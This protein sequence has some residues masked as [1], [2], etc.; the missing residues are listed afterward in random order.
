MVKNFV[1]IE[2]KEKKIFLA[3]LKKSKKS[4]IFLNPKEIML[5]D[6]VLV[7]DRLFNLSQVYLEI[8]KYL[9]DQKIKIKKA[10]IAFAPIN[11]KSQLEQKLISL[12]IALTVSKTGLFVEKILGKSLL[13][14]KLKK[15][16]AMSKLD[17]QLDFFNEFKPKNKDNYIKFLILFLGLFTLIFLGIFMI[18]KNKNKTLKNLEKQFSEISTE[19][20]NLLSKKQEFTK[21]KIET[22]KLQIKSSVIEKSLKKQN[23]PKNYLEIISKNIPENSCL[24][25]IKFLFNKVESKNKNLEIEGFTIDQKHVSDFMNKLL[26]SKRFVNLKIEVLEKTK[27]NKKKQADLTKLKLYKFKISGRV[28]FS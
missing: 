3:I 25:S 19:N 13:E 9:N 21:L 8:K 2:L 6:Y 16:F 7:N 11:T 10:I 27:I 20:K 1:Y 23:N 24:N 15:D 18:Q 5:K 28:L 17:N 14:E 4:F 12:Q 26:Q 22:N